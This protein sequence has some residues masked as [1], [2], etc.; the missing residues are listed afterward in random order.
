MLL[1][2]LHKL[3]SLY[4]IR[5]RSYIE[6]RFFTLLDWKSN[7]CKNNTKYNAAI[8]ITHPKP[9]ERTGE[10]EREREREIK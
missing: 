6:R 5:A 7:E 10:R 8:T 4:L 3:N 9:K 1:S 2:I